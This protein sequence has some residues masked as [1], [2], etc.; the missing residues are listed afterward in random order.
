MMF[1]QHLVILIDFYI[2]IAAISQ[3]DGLKVLAEINSE[4]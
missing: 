2:Y 1:F 3:P 4:V